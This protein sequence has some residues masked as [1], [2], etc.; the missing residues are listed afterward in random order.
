MDLIAWS[1]A[2]LCGCGWRRFL[3]CECASLAP[4][5]AKACTCWMWT[6]N[7]CWTNFVTDRATMVSDLT[8]GSKAADGW[9]IWG[10]LLTEEM[11]CIT[12]YVEKVWLYVF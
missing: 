12:R 10:N 1:R 2:F 3:L 7:E 6:L 5:L 9:R 11:I 4:P 8:K